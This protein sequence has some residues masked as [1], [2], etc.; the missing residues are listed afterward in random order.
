[1]LKNIKVFCLG[2]C[3]FYIFKQIIIWTL[4][5]CSLGKNK[6]IFLN[7]FLKKK[8]LFLVSNEKSPPTNYIIANKVTNAADNRTYTYIYKICQQPVWTWIYTRTNQHTNMNIVTS[9]AL[10]MV[11]L[12]INYHLTSHVTQRHEILKYPI[13]LNSSEFFFC[14]DYLLFFI[15]F[16]SKKFIRDQIQTL[17]CSSSVGFFGLY[18]T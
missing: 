4:R 1:M 12:F 17:Y 15:I 3:L 18:T 2:V 5:H 13:P 6:H 16:V 11:S 10:H 9:Y 8:Q 7:V 14:L